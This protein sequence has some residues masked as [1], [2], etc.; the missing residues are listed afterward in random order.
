MAAP[1]IR[2]EI[3]TTT[4]RIVMEM[5]GLEMGGLEMV[6]H[7]EREAETEQG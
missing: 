4:A 1:G 6:D 7:Q 3:A 2:S 5:E